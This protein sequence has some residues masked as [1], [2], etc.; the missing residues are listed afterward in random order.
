MAPLREHRPS[1]IVADQNEGG[2][3]WPALSTISTISLAA[4]A[5]IAVG[6][7]LYAAS[8]LLLPIASAF[9]VGVTL[10]PIARK[11]EVAR[12]P[13]AVSAVLIV[14]GVT[15]V[16]ALTIALILPRVSELANALPDLIEKW[17]DRISDFAAPLR[18]YGLGEGENGPAFPLPS[19]SFA[20]VPSTIGFLWPPI[21]GF[22]FFLVVL[23][24]FIAKWPDLRRALV[25]TFAS[26]DSR[27]AALK[28][29]NGVEAGLAS[30]L[31][32]VSLINLGVGV[33]T[34]TICW[35][36]GTPNALGFGALATAL[37]FIP[38]VGPAATFIILIVA[39]VATAPELIQGLVP[40]ACYALLVTI[41]GHFVTPTV[42]GRQLE[43]NGLAV[44]LSLAFWT[45]LWGPVGAFLS[46]PI[47]IVALI[48]HQRL[49]GES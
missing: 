20:W 37:N 3:T 24:L 29:V 14:A 10:S 47:L 36:A 17:R 41:E 40:A 32:T 22:L 4:L 39:G 26:H 49:Y 44:L 35:I 9:V 45:W 23:L 11:L 34:G 18:R 5:T 28:I 33:I 19:L 27:L 25:M 8:A 31:M 15:L 6:F 7:A 2:L 43:L 21:A 12:V 16:I 38:I 1:S 48:V 46:S 30:Y 13:R 42:V